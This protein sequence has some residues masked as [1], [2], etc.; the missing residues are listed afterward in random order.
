M[1]RDSSAIYP[2]AH[3]GRD[4]QVSIGRR[5][6]IVDD[7]PDV[8]EAI[9]ILMTDWGFSVEACDTFESGRAKLTQGGALD[10]LLVD[11]RLGMF[12]GL[13]LAHLARQMNP[14]LK[15]IVMSGFDDD[16]LRA[17]AEQIG[18]VFLAKPV[19]PSTLERQV[20]R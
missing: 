1:S 7:A 20:H 6:L 14:A 9:N 13:Q 5:A 8:L 17:E 15:I 3:H 2:R 18:A 4:G 19:E 10:V 16:L 11:V 12:N